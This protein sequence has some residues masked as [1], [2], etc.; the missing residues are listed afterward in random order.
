MLVLPVVTLW[1]EKYLTMSG[2]QLHFQP[3]AWHPSSRIFKEKVRQT[4]VQGSLGTVN[5]SSEQ[6]DEHASWLIFI[7]LTYHVA[8]HRTDKNT[9]RS[10]YWSNPSNSPPAS[11]VVLPG[12]LITFCTLR[13][14]L[15]NEETHG[16]LTIYTF[17][18]QSAIHS[19]TLG[20]RYPVS[21]LV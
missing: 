10:L 3:Q 21:Q 5:P 17:L 12:Q 4:S 2:Q 15:L 16:Q 20:K 13:G 1:D 11:S 19:A 9:S 18:Y 14:S 7:S 6:E 8:L